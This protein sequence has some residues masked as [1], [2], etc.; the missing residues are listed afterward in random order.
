MFERRWREA[1]LAVFWICA[2]SVNTVV[3]LLIDMGSV[4]WDYQD[5]TL[6]NLPCKRIH[7]AEESPA[8]RAAWIVLRS[9]MVIVIGPTPPGTGVIAADLGATVA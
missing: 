9:S 6:R 8:I 2:V 4:R 1:D 5:R 3:K 7:M